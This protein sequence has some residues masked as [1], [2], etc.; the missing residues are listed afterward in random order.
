MRS[1]EFHANR[2]LLRFTVSCFVLLAVPATWATQEART[3]NQQ[4]APSTATDINLNFPTLRGSVDTLRVHGITRNGIPVLPASLSVRALSPGVIE[5]ISQK[6]EV[7]DWE[8]R[9]A[10]TS[11]VFGFGERFNTLNQQDSI[12]KNVVRD[13]PFAKGSSSYAPIPFFMSLRGYG[14]WLD[15]YSEASFDLNVTSRPDIVI[16]LTG[17]HLR[18]VFFEG[19]RFATILQRFTAL[20]GRSKLPPYWAFAP[21]KSRNWHPDMAAVYEDIEKYR[22]LGLPASVLVLDSPWATNYNTFEVNQKQFTDPEAMVAKTKRLGFKLCLWLT[23]FVN[24]AT[25]TPSEPELIGKIPLGPA[26]NFEAGEEGGF[27]LK[28]SSGDVYLTDWW[29]GRGAMVDF[30]NPAARNWWRQQVRK[31]VQL[32][33]SAFKDDDGEG[34]FLGEVRFSDGE[35]PRVVRNRYAVLY[36][37]T[38]QE[39]IDTDLH[40][41]GVLLYRSG[42]VGSTNLPFLW[43]GDNEANFSSENG[44]PGVVLAG[45]NAGLSGISMWTNDL[46]GYIKSPGSA[47]DPVLFVRWTEFAA[48]SPVMQLHSGVNLGP[49]DY[50]AR[51]LDIFRQYSRLHMSL[52]PYRY[53]AAQ[54][55]ARTGMPIMRALVLLHQDDHQASQ[56]IDEYYFGPDLLVA[57]V[58][59]PASQRSVYLPAGDWISYWSGERL[60]GQQTI[61]VDASLDRLPLFVRSGAVIPK[62]PDDVMTLVPGDSSQSPTVQHLDDRREYEIYPG[63]HS[64]LTDFEGRVLS[65]SPGPS[66]TVMIEGPEAKVTLIWRFEQP[67]SATMNGKVLDLRRLQDGASVTV[68]H[69]DRTSVIWH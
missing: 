11:P 20:T 17:D 64:I 55:S 43:A 5:I 9:A 2:R 23:P 41:D 56:T 37:Q 36:N 62:I 35:D 51:A 7:A 13:I 28:T 45:L 38:M 61:V 15:T 4:T 12:V 32:G 25:D 1:A 68:S 27:F 39:V 6:S 66:N 46:G 52:F 60:H 18:L 63:P 33:A 14:L 42:S 21:W 69:H 44:L 30:A 29:K 31:A 65:F 10:D 48:F 54:E 3:P 22:A 53:N 24:V 49:W 58:L 59:S 19:P 57:P 8:F 50:G 67:T 26:T 16:R 34:N 40:G 47:P